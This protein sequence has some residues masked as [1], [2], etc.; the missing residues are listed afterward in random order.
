MLAGPFARDGRRRDR[1]PA[2]ARAN[3][4]RA[5]P[6]ARCAAR[7][8]RVR[9]SCARATSHRCRSCFPA[10]G[11]VTDKRPDNFLYIGLIKRLFPDAQDRPHDAQSAGQLPVGLFPA[12]RPQHGLRARSDGYRALLSAIPAP[13][14]ALEIALRRRHPRLRL[15][16][17][18]ARAP[19]GGRRGC[20]LSAGSIGRRAAWP[21]TRCAT[22]SRRRA[23]GRCASRS[24]S[25]RP[26]AGA[27]TRGISRPLEADWRSRRHEREGSPASARAIRAMSAQREGSPVSRRE[28]TGG[29]IRH[30]D[31]RGARISTRSRDDPRTRGVRKA[32]APLRR[33]RSR[34]RRR[35]I[36]TAAGCRSA[37]G[38]ESRKAGRL[39]ALF[40]QLFDVSRPSRPVARGPLRASGIP[41]AGLRARA[42]ARRSPASRGRADCGRFE[43]AVLDWN[44][45]AIE[46]Y[47][48]LGAAVLPDW[49]ICRVV[50]DALVALA[51]SAGRRDL[52]S[53]LTASETAASPAGL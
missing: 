41:T 33:H 31:P 36:R 35:A 40:S 12:S 11:Y 51:E 38:V 22:R 24:T 8:A 14:G 27:T 25:A 45:P 19:A 42:A 3:R 16:R 2:V 43:W 39:R 26:A 18:R 32:R 29:G 34:P 4:A 10:R 5:V 15:R 28:R 47:R 9:R 1:S 30:H 37:G 13:D 48:T 7:A 6:G 52:A 49:R 50:G 44:A 17:V 21:F 20:S 23:S 46:F 53:R